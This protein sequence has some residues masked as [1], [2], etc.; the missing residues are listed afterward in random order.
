MLTCTTAAVKFSVA[1]T[2]EHQAYSNSIGEGLSSFWA[3]VEYLQNAADQ[4]QPI[5]QVEQTIF[6]RLLVTGRWMLQGVNPRHPLFFREYAA[7]R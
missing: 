5:H 2:P 6:R 3:L 1:S 4:H 7:M